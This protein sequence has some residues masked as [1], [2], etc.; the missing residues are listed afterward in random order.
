[1]RYFDTL[2]QLRPAWLQF[3]DTYNVT[4]IERHGLISL[5]TFRQQQVQPAALAA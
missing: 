4:F 3:R 1:M 2:E 5:A